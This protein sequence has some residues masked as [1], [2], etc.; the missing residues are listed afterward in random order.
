MASYKKALSFKPDYAEAHYNM[1]NALK[2]Q[3]KLDE[4]IAAYNR[5]LS[6]KPDFAKAHRNL[7]LIKKYT[8]E[9]KQFLHVQEIY[10]RVG[11]TEDDKCNLSFTLAKMYEDTGKLN[12]AF[13][14]LSEGNAL[15]KRFLKYSINEDKQ[16]FTKLKKSQPLLSNNSTEL[17]QS[18]TK[19]TPIFILGMPRSGTTLV[20]QII[21]SHSEVFGGGEL[22]YIKQFGFKL[23]TEVAHV[24]NLNISKF[25]EKYLSKLS[26]LTKSKRFVTDKMPHNFRFIPLIYTAFPEAKIVHVQRDPIATCWSNYKHYFAQ[27]GLYCYDLQDVVSYYELYKDLMKLWQ[28]NYGDRIYSKLRNSHN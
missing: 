10:K 5:A 22:D 14:H 15:R 28:S 23:A 13:K 26:K 2:D 1:G 19:S 18:S 7:S 4:A 21:S 6:I 27:S 24:T 3:G 12:Q 25:R 8:V 20:E 17:E 11:L 16:L 9:D